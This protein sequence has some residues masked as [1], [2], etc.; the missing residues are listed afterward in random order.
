LIEENDE[1]KFVGF[2]VQVMINYALERQ[3]TSTA[4][5]PLMI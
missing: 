5:P 1:K 3:I 2:N 4:E